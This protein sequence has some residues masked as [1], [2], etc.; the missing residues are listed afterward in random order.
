MARE[1]ILRPLSEEEYAK[2]PSLSRETIREALRK[3]RED[4]LR[5]ASKVPIT[6]APVAPAGGGPCT[7]KIASRNRT[8]VA[9]GN[10]R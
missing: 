5:M 3:G 7:T 9:A 10:A 1:D 2:L 6:A 4:M 8:R